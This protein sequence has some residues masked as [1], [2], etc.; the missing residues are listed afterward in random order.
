MNV[1][2]AGGNTLINMKKKYLTLEELASYANLSVTTL[3]RFVKSGMPH[4]RMGRAIRVRPN[5]F[6]AWID[7]FRSDG[8]KNGSKARLLNAWEQLETEAV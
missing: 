1:T 2:M 7:R 4:Y 6:D 8:S 3:R 5:D